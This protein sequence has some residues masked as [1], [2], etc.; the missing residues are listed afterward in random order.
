MATTPTQLRSQLVLLSDNAE[1]DLAALWAQLNAATVH[2]GLFDVLPAIVDDYGDAAATLTADWY[3]EH[4]AELNVPGRFA[5]DIPA[6]PQ[7]GAEALAGWG[8]Q[9]AQANW[10]T[11]LAQISGGLVL[12]VF[13]ASRDLLTA[14]TVDDPHA[15]GW[16]RAGRGECGF[17]RMLIGRGA[18]YTKASVRFG[19]HDHCKCVAV[20]AFS[21]RAVPVKPYRATDRSITDADRAR[22]RD[23]IANNT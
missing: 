7:L 18:V 5:A 3:D 10:D 8:N 19:A 22:V 4:R 6:N 20:P 13:T 23:W 16:Q 12:R 21:H 1:A 2:D 15:R 11:A 17:C 14:A 9:L